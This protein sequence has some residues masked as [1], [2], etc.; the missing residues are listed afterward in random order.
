[1]AASQPPKNDLL[2][3][4][5][6]H[7]PGILVGSKCILQVHNVCRTA[8]GACADL[9]EQVNREMAAASNDM[10]PAPIAPNTPFE[11]GYAHP[12]AASCAKCHKETGKNLMK[13]TR[14]QLTR[15][16]G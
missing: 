3:E 13:C 14:C 7:H 9:L 6:H 11:N 16:C 15:Y 8:D 10:N 2:C 4:H 5:L 1:M 12:R